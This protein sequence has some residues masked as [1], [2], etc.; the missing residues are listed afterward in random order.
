MSIGVPGKTSSLGHLGHPVWVNLKALLIEENILKKKTTTKQA[1]RY[2][3]DNGI[4]C[5]IMW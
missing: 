3:K 2:T 4:L 5:L 1:S